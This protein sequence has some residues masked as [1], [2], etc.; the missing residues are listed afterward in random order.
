MFRYKCAYYKYGYRHT[1]RYKARVKKL[2]R[3][4]SFLYIVNKTFIK[5]N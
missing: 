3:M 1:L 4:L 5:V 2:Y